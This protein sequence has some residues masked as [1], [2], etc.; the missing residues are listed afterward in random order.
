MRGAG[1]SVCRHVE[2]IVLLMLVLAGCTV[3]RITPSADLA[4]LF[5]GS[6]S[7]ELKNLS[8]AVDAP[9]RSDQGQSMVKQI[10]RLGLFGSVGRLDDSDESPDL[11]IMGYGFEEPIYGEG[12]SCFENMMT[13]LTLG[14][15]PAT[16]ERQGKFTMSLRNAKGNVLTLEEPYV[17]K[18]IE[19]WIGVPMAAS[20]DWEYLD[21]RAEFLRT[22]IL[23]RSREITALVSAG[24]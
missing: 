11:I 3:E 7:D 18:I 12:I 8:V 22:V 13:P 4:A 19:G 1:S 10:S 21:A 23:G 2:T 5:A 24:S 6:R 20:S 17:S 15:V 16:C 9:E 14:L